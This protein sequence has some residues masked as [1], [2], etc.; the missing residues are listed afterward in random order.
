VH[1]GNMVIRNAADFQRLEELRVGN[2]D[3]LDG[4]FDTKPYVTNRSDIVALMILE[5]QVNAQN[6]IARVNFDVRTAIDRERGAAK[7]AQGYDQR[8]VELSPALRKTVEESVEPLVL[9]LLFADET[10]LTDPI[11]GDPRFVTQ[12]VSR[13]VR[14]PKGRSLRDLDLQTRMF[15]YPLSYVI[16]SPAFDA[17]P[18]A[19]R[20]AAYA[21]FAAV[22]RGTD[23]TEGMPRLAAEDRTAILEILTATKSEFASSLGR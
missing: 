7:A 6:A 13:S 5:H 2:I 20:E 15:R 10:K 8:L 17:L 19:A 22:L 16:Y 1:L 3:T 21:R 9:T 23:E 11:G 12:F 4:L 14:D 18:R